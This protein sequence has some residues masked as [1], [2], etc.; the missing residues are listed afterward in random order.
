MPPMATCNPRI[1]PFAG[2]CYGGA[3]SHTRNKGFGPEISRNG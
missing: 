3:L 2:P 1:D